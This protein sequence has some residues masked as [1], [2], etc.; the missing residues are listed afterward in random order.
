MPRLRRSDCAGPGLVRRARGRGFELLD[1]RGKR[2][3]D[4]ATRARV[5]ALSIP[6]A[7]RDVWICADE[8][9]HLQATGVDGAGRRQ[10][11]YHPDWHRQRARRKF[12]AMVDFARALPELRAAVDRDLRGDPQGREAVLAAMTRLLDRG[13]FRI[14][15]E[16]YAERNETYGLATLLRDH[17]TVS[18]EVVAFDYPAKHG[19]R[20]VQHVV[21]SVSADLV[22]S[23][24]RRRGGGPE[25]FAH[26]L[27]GRWC[28][29]K[30]ADVNAY[31]KARTGLDVSAKDFRTWHATVLAAVAVAVSAPAARTNTA[32]KR[33]VARAVGEVAEYLGN[34][35]AVARNSYI[36][37]RVFDRFAA[38]HTIGGALVALA[39]GDPSAP[40]REGEVEEAVIALLEGDR[41]VAA[42]EH[43]REIVRLAA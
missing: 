31:L 7:W 19:L 24:K 16:E 14:G 42:V 4:A 27:G 23:L 39:A 2:V 34:T 18:G 25:L 32:R 1:S 5:D 28:D 40:A 11:L 22:R 33:A 38:G 10:Y 21:D 35:P 20:R 29:V 26:K 9:G 17:A 13:F 12:N 37:P 15:C 8:R 43:V 6:P 36:D 3:S 41:A 30:S